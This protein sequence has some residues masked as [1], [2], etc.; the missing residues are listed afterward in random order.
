MN[1][2]ETSAQIDHRNLGAFESNRAPSPAFCH[3]HNLMF[4]AYAAARGGMS[5]EGIENVPE[6][7]SLLIP[8]PHSSHG[9]HALVGSL[10]LT[11][12]GRHVD[13]VAKKEFWDKP[14]GSLVGPYVALGGG[15]PIDRSQ[16]FNQQPELID[17]LRLTKDNGR[18]IVVYIHGKRVDP[19]SPITPKSLKTGPIQL[20]KILDVPIVPIGLFGVPMGLAG[21]VSRDHMAAVFGKPIYPDEFDFTLADLDIRGRAND[22]LKAARN[23]LAIE[24]QTLKERAELIGT[25]NMPR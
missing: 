18:P 14:M 13:F 16:S 2:P 23:L 24:M 20:A 15:R 19:S 9:D 4:R 3:V 12:L 7:S 22:G 10:I 17:R 1:S 21:A 25:A 6:G 8:G 11:N 5:Q